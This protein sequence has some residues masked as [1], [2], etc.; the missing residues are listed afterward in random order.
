MGSFY[1]PA[2]NVKIAG[3]TLAANVTRSIIELVYDNSLTTADMFTL[4]LNNADMSLTD[5]ALFDVGKNVE[6]YMGYAGDLQPMMLGEIA[7]VN[8]SF[9][10]DGAPMMTITGYDKSQ[11]M[12]HNTPEP[13]TFK[14]MPDSAIAAAIAGENLLIPIVDP[15]PT[16]VR[17]SV[18]QTG[19][20]WAF[21]RDLA[22]RNFFELFVYWDR[23]YFRFPRPQ[24]QLTILEWG[25]NLSSFSPRLSTSGQFG[26]Q[27]LRGYDYKLAQTIVAVLP[28]VTLG[29]DLSDIIERLGSSFLEQLVS[30]G[31]YVVRD[32]PINNYLDALAVA[33]SVLLQLLEGLF[34]GSGSCI[35]M[36]Q[37]RAG[38][39]VQING[40]GQR[41]SGRYKLSKVTHT[42]SDAG[43]ITNFEVSQNVNAAL[44]ESLR[45]KLGG[46]SKPDGQ[47]AVNGVVVAKVENNID[48]EGL[49]RVQLSFPHLSDVN[50]SNWARVATPMAG[51]S[52]GI[53]FLP[54]V[55]DEVL[56]T[57]EQG[58][59]DKPVVLGGLWNGLSRPPVVNA[60]PNQTKTIKLKKGL[61]VQLDETKGLT[62][63][64]GLGSSISLD[65][66]G[67]ITI[68]AVGDVTIKSGPA[69]KVHL[70]P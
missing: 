60:G 7:A 19:S 17:E 35:G 65:L 16:G 2:F 18:Q 64:N 27:V 43:Y 34:E 1:A 25:K 38:D 6:I 30:L 33:K 62:L 8:P 68:Q 32:Q 56:A 46:S 28:A 58:D 23:L 31:R 70:N 47:S 37:L 54:D 26:I 40:V 51:S 53:F 50:L 4:K 55:G 24:T 11:K 3:L 9:P 69:G 48:P 15:S 63:Q 45:K 29:G 61:E 49:G 10:R 39:Y 42:I 52:S 20:D 59:V 36:P 66:Q 67:N 41:F 5:S 57:F 21:L 13:F 44:L 12:R 14:Y 22:R